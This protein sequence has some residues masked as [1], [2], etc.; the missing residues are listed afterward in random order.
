VPAHLLLDDIKA[1][2]NNPH[3][4]PQEVTP[5]LIGGLGRLIKETI[6]DILENSGLE[7]PFIIEDKAN[8]K[9]M[10]DALE[11]LGIAMSYWEALMLIE[12]LKN[13][14]SIDVEF[15]EGV[16]SGAA[17]EVWL[18]SVLTRNLSLQQRHPS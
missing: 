5:E 7:P 18:K 3:L 15:N 6:E 14:Y 4:L 1:V 9:I 2:Q 12:E 10:K 16:I 17:A 11:K 8:I 13:W